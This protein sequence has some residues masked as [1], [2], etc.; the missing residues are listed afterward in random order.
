MN[1][2]DEL[3]LAPPEVLN[4]IAR[5]GK[6]RNKVLLCGENTFCKDCKVLDGQNLNRVALNNSL[7]RITAGI[8]ERNKVWNH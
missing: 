7:L 3:C 6:Q 4:E 1:K 5:N 2:K 8:R